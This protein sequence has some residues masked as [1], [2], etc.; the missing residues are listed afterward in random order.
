MSVLIHGDAVRGKT[1]HEYWVWAAL[2]QRCTN[3][4]AKGY[5]NYGGRGVSVCARWRDSYDAFLEDMGRRPSPGHCIDRIDND[6]PYSPENCRWATRLEQNRNRRG[7]RLIELAGERV[8]LAVAAE[9]LG[10]TYETARKRLNRGE[11]LPGGARE[12]AHA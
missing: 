6:G 12:V 8:C 3:P 5:P 2:I 1:A 11:A 9:R 4:H 10:L 7:R